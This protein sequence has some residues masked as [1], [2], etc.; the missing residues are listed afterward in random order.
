MRRSLVLLAG[1][2]ST[3]ILGATAASAARPVDA[4]L[5]GSADGVPGFCAS[6]AFTVSG[7]YA[8]NGSFGNGTYSGTV[9]R[10]G[11]CGEIGIGFVTLG[12]PSPV[13][14]TFTFSG[15]G[16]S[17]TASG[18][19]ESLY[20]VGGAHV[21]YFPTTLAL[22]M[23]DGTKRYKHA[24]GS[25]SLSVEAGYNGY[26]GSTWSSGTLAGSIDPSG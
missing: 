19:G 21:T 1:T 8:G 14:A 13:T 25:L 15:P 22:T 10:Q 24:G 2:V 3:L 16:G 5:Q 26:D 6:T 11:A 4:T 12:P 9:T 17:F 20:S 18:S 23:T 7:S